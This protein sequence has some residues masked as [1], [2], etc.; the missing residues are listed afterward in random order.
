M[1]PRLS[2]FEGLTG[3][4]ICFQGSLPIP[5]KLVPVIGGGSVPCH[6]TFSIEMSLLCG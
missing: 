4:G 1:S 3:P 6:V 2:S 5:D